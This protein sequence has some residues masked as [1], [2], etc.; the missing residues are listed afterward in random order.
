MATLM[1]PQVMLAWMANDAPLPPEHGAPMRLVVPF[2]Y[3]A[4]SVKAITGIAFTATSFPTQKPW[5][6]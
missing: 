6:A 1:H 2:R 3:G 4:R 5:P